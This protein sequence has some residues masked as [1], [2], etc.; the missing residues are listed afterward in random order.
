MKNKKLKLKLKPLNKMTISNLEDYED[1]DLD[2]LFGGT[3][4]IVTTT[5]PT[6]RIDGR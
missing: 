3:G 1:K 4:P 5:V 6:Y 2:K